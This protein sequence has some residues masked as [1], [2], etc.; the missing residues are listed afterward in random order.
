MSTPANARNVAENTRRPS[1]TSGAKSRGPSSRVAPRERP[2]ASEEVILEDSASNAPPRRTVSEAQKANGGSW[3]ANERQTGRLHLGT[4][5]NLQIK[6]RS[7]VKVTSR[8]DENEVVRNERHPASRSSQSVE[9]SAPAP[10]K[11]KKSLREWGRKVLGH[12]EKVL[13]SGQHSALETPSLPYRSH[14]GSLGRPNIYTS[15]RI[16]D[17]RIP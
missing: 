3:T 9:E 12:I 14:H 6:T 5:D 16:L 8:D 10:K 17:S 1:T 11:E 2:F 13:M 15:S 7:P 4:R